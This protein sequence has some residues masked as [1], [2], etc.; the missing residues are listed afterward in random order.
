MPD[1]Q[2]ISLS[3]K[4]TS[5]AST[6][7]D[8]VAFDQCSTFNLPA[9]TIM[10]KS[11]RSG[12]RVL[13]PAD[14]FGLLQNCVHYQ[15]ITGHVEQLVSLDPAI[16]EH[17]NQLQ[18]MLEDLKKQ[19]VMDSGQ[20]LL[21]RLK[22]AEKTTKQPAEFAGTF[23]RTCDRPAQLKRLLDSLD[24]Q[25]QRF[26]HR[27]RYIVVDDSRDNQSQQQNQLLCSNYAS[28]TNLYV[29]YY[30][31]QQQTDFHNKLTQAFP[32]N[33]DTINW[34]L[35]RSDDLSEDIFSGGRLLNHIVLLAA[36]K[37]FTLFDDDAVCQPYHSP[38]MKHRW[39][40]KAQPKDCWFYEDRDLMF[41]EIVSADL[42][43]LTRHLDVLGKPLGQVTDDLSAVEL[44]IDALDGV[45]SQDGEN[46]KPETSILVTRNGTF[47]DPGTSSMNW[48]YQQDG[49][50]LE[51]LTEEDER[52][53]RYSGNRTTWLGSHCFRAVNENALMTTTLTGIDGSQLIPPTGSYYRNEDYLL[54]RLLKFIHPSSV[55][56]EFPWG[57]PHLPEPPR[58]WH[59]AKLNEPRTVGVL[60]FLAD[61]A[62]NV[63]PMCLAELPQQRL[64]YLGETY[65][66]L[67]DA[68]LETL[69]DGIEENLL[70]TRAATITD[71]QLVLDQ[72]ADQP[73]SWVEDVQ[74][75]ID[76]NQQR[77]AQPEQ[78]LFPDAGAGDTLQK[79]LETCQQVLDMFGE[80]LILWPLLWE[81]CKDNDLLK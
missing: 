33:L 29:E 19:G 65:R 68:E 2:G 20:Q 45:T 16:A 3:I 24:Q 78:N 79:Q 28:N 73:Q 27:H 18:Q 62:N 14:M 72:H 39:S 49:K 53:K 48:I 58:Q 34:L 55:I 25:Q 75:I 22:L 56:F 50:T 7:A 4:S 51:H 81:Y 74:R 35:T 11:H 21:S 66:T 30:G 69:R 12:M 10:L 13:V 38:E 26:G 44:S 59:A 61:I 40:F 57:L 54:S 70:N 23:I 43:P 77:L 15:S 64:R 76:A 42:D 32:D 60:G 36:G 41:S 52:F 37:R 46:L 6:E 67:A 8:V 9:A 5:S 47:G 31:L 63:Q 71:M 1:Y 80:G 17:K